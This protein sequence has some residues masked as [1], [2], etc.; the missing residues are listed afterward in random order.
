LVYASLVCRFVLAFVFLLASVSKLVAPSDF[1]RAVANYQL[2][3]FRWGR[4][5]AAW[6]PR[7]ELAIA[8]CLLSGALLPV[9]AAVAMVLLLGFAAAVAINLA[10]GR[11]IE[12]GCGGFAAPRK[13]GPAFVLRNLLLA[14]GAALA[15]ASPVAA[16]T[17]PSVSLATAAPI[18]TRDAL[19]VVIAAA[20][21]VV[22]AS[23]VS[24][25][26]RMYHAERALLRMLPR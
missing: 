7:L 11:R 4:I 13:I 19:A 20:S 24:E 3:P 1:S 6:L 10:R 18:S 15:A 14:G 9:A 25:T 17:V 8:L 5:V 22:F 26:R 12:C 21:A 23:V 16:L 2:L